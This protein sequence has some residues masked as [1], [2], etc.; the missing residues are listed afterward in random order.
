M[1]W[2][3][4]SACHGASRI[5]GERGWFVEDDV[6]QRILAFQ[7]KEIEEDEGMGGGL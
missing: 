5:V 6:H 7:E 2:K 3:H 4:A 1:W